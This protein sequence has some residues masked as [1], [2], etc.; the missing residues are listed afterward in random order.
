MLICDERMKRM[1]LL[2]SLEIEDLSADQRELAECIGMDAY[3]K[4]L[5]NYAGSCV[6][7]CKP[8]TVTL[9]ARNAQIRKEFNGYNYLDLAK[10]YNLSEISIRRIV[11]P[12]IA[13]V[14]AAPLPGQVSFF[15]DDT[16]I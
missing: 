10:K 12:V 16:K 8:D 5:K 3:K 14:R 6:Y 13:E 11:S 1:N 15:D 2:D 4:L 9:N 7:V